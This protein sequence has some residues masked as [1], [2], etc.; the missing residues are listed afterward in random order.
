MLLQIHKANKPSIILTILLSIFLTS[1]TVVYSEKTVSAGT[2]A[3]NCRIKI[4]KSGC[5]KLLKA[6]DSKPANERTTCKRKATAKKDDVYKACRSKED[7][8]SCHSKL[9]S[10]CADKRGSALESCKKK[11]AQPLA[12]RSAGASTNTGQ[13]SGTGFPKTEKNG[14][15]GTGD[16]A[17][18]T[19]FDFG[20]SG[21]GNPIQDVAYTIIRFLSIGVGIV[22]VAS[23]IYAGIMYSSSEGSPEATASAK[24]RVQNAV[25]GLIFYMFIFAL[26]Q[27]LVPGGLF[28]P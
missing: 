23:I 4:D 26:V 3:T 11:T 2:P 10:G 15:C 14:K 7:P 6:C 12:G 25:A 22:L 8:Q 17:V 18:E 24:K 16:N 28:A 27:Y 21:T 5:E 9:K 13:N 1:L 19:N 20:C